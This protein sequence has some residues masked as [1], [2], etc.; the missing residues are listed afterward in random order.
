MAYRMRN[1]QS[2]TNLPT[3]TNTSTTVD[4]TG[5]G[6]AAGNYEFVVF[7]RYNDG[8]GAVNS[9]FSCVDVKGYNGSGNKADW[10]GVGGS[11]SLAVSVYPNPTSGELYA[12]APQGSEVVLMDINGRV[13][14]SQVIE[15]SETKFDMSA[16]S[17]GVYMLRVQTSNEIVTKRIIKD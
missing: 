1:T 16:L 3:T 8:A 9:N 12:S 17:E 10:S 15:N 13:I 14:A 7:T 11:T 6:L 4:F 2:Y 5:T